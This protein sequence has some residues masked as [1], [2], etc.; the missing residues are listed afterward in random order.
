MERF[1]GADHDRRDD[2]DYRQRLIE[3]LDAMGYSSPSA[4]KAELANELVR[5]YRLTREGEKR[6]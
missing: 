6:G 3:K 2:E 5:R 1:E 4:L